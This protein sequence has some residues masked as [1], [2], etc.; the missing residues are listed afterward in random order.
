MN[1]RIFIALELSEEL[2]RKIFYTFSHKIK[3]EN[4]KI[5]P[6]KNL[7]ITLKFIGHYPEEKIA[8]L[9]EK[10]KE[11]ECFEEFEIIFSEIGE[12]DA[13]VL[14]VGIKD[15]GKLQE[16]AE[17]INQLL[18][19]H[20]RFSPHLTIARIKKQNRKEIE[21]IVEELQKTKFEEK[22]KVKEIALMESNL[23]GEKP[24]YKTIYSFKLK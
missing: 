15:D 17:K 16:I 18:E 20:D 23:D 10:L 5:V 19:T 14:W 7:H 6:E 11:I 21:K 22:F 3:S 24:V 9:V 1:L 8:E 4:A 13:R 12:F 2:K